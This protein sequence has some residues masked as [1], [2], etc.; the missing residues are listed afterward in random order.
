MKSILILS[1]SLMAITPCAYCQVDTLE[2]VLAG[3]IGLP[4]SITQLYTQNINGDS[5]NEIILCT[6]HNV[7]VYGSAGNQLLWISP[8]LINPRDLQFADFNGD[9]IPDFA[10]HTDTAIIIFR[11]PDTTA[12]YS[13]PISPSLFKVFTTGDS[14]D[15]GV[16]DLLLV[17]Q[18]PFEFGDRQDTAWISLKYGPDFS[19]FGDNCLTLT[20]YDRY[21]D[22][23][24]HYY[25]RE[26]VNKILLA[27]IGSGLYVQPL[28]FLNTSTEKL[29]HNTSPDEGYYTSELSGKYYMLD[30]LEFQP[31]AIFSRGFADT[32]GVYDT[33]NNHIVFSPSN[34]AYIDYGSIADG[35][36]VNKRLLKFTTWGLCDSTEI[37][38]S[39]SNQMLTCNW[40]ACFGEM[41]STLSGSEYCYGHANTIF[42][43]SLIY[44][45][46]LWS[47]A[48]PADSV[49]VISALNSSSIFN[50]PEV[51]LKCIQP[52]QG[53]LFVNGRTGSV[54]AILP[55][56]SLIISRIGDISGDGNDE[57]L[58]ANGSTLKIYTLFSVTGTEEDVVNPDQFAL[59]GNYPN[60]FNSQTT[61]K[62]NL[63]QKSDIVLE[64]YDILGRKIEVVEKTD[65]PAGAN[66]IVWDAS[67][68]PSGAY[69]YRLTAGNE[70]IA[71]RMVLLK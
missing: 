56:P 63:P 69:F 54:D 15:D 45:S 60:P 27:K 55:D 33:G 37:F 52:Q 38:N 23:W 44:N 25:S 12:V 71:A 30:P 48:D 46:L 66:Q 49:E 42:Q 51:V 40:F 3:S 10:V 11:L 2:A 18:E 20:N 21:P 65:Q 58:S 62:Y 13:A 6:P 34:Y 24:S 67:D 17:S 39:V 47:I 61:I 36:I 68:K 50:S 26:T 8:V 4:D 41:N 9:S 28:I 35:S 43:R 64:I 22:Q 14:D 31:L 1:I 5:L 29:W 7:Y 16:P 57:I 32:L 19:R 59:I 70:Q 53:Y